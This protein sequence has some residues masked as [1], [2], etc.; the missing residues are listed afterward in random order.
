MITI[1]QIIVYME[2]T[3]AEDFLAGN[4]VNL[5]HTQTA[6]GV[7]MAAAESVKDSESARRFRQ[8]AAQAA[9]KLEDVE[10]AEQQ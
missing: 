4:K 9:N 6:A 8:V 5:R 2:R 1:D 10:K 7:L 3:I